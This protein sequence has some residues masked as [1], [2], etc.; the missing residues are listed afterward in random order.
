MERSAYIALATSEGW[1]ELSPDDRELAPE[2]AKLGC[3]ATP[4][5]WNDPAVDWRSFDLVVIR[6]CWDYHLRPDEFRGWL[7]RLDRLRVPVGNTSDTIRWNMHKRYLRELATEGIPVVSEPQQPTDKVVV[8]PA[9]SAS[10]YETHVFD[11]LSAARE[12]IG[13]LGDVIVQEFIPEIVTRGEWS[14]ML[15]G[16]E[17]SHAVRKLPKEG[18]FRVQHEFGGRYLLEAPPPAVMTL[19]QRVLSVVDVL[20]ARVDIV[21]AARGPL[22]MELELIEPGLFLKMGPAAARRFA[23]AISLQSR[24]A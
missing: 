10:A 15:F 16:G 23:A 1:P 19:A 5:V 20:Y 9:I 3:H 22:L 6:S 21:E 14:L 12:T 8:K 4:V 18:D 24:R 7:D 11:D 13:R 17:F 2:L